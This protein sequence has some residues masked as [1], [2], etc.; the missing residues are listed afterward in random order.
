MR[1]QIL[2]DL[3]KLDSALQDQTD[4]EKA[5]SGRALSAFAS[6][7][8]RVGCDAGVRVPLEDSGLT[9]ATVMRVAR[10]LTGLTPAEVANKSGVEA[11][12]IEQLEA[13]KVRNPAA[14]ALYKIAPIYKLDYPEMM[15]ACGSVRA[16]LHGKIRAL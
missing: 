6:S 11:R 16:R 14:W 4:A 5:A 15:L 8:R 1:H 10:E 12:Y 13:G 7:V 2:S 9:F 3:R